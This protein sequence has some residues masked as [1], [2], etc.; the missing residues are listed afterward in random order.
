MPPFFISM[1]NCDIS[2]LRLIICILFLPFFLLIDPHLPM[3]A[4]YLSAFAFC[5]ALA[6]YLF[7]R[8]REVLNSTITLVIDIAVITLFIFFNAKYT[9][10]LSFLYIF[11]IISLSFEIKPA[12]LIL[13]ALLSGSCYLTV[14]II[15]ES[16]L[17]FVIIEIVLLFI[18]AFFTRFLVQFIQQG[19]Y[20][21][22]N[23]DTLTKLQNRRYFNHVLSEMVQSK[24]PFSLILLDLDNF[25]SLND[26]QGHHHGDY[27][28]K[29]IAAILNECTRSYDIVTRFGGDEFAIILPNS[30]KETSKNIANR[31]RN[32]VLVNPKLL[33]YPNITL[34]LGIATFPIDAGNEEDIL[35]K[36]DE[37]LY[38]A[39]RMGKNYVYVF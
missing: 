8:L 11:P 19:Y 5:Y 13:T 27:V 6:L 30:N 39:K 12:K 17:L 35:K 1:G 34:S 15:Q 26:S 31:I 29:V 14:A 23:Q 37:A 9:Y 3:P 18:T 33:V 7:P 22:A 38:K 2:F 28:L 36:A 4:Y 25:K 21:Q 16:Y 10:I 20:R 32:L 24:T